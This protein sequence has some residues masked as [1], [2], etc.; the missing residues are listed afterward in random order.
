MEFISNCIV[1]ALTTIV[2]LFLCVFILSIFII[3][4]IGLGYSILSFFQW[5]ESKLR[6]NK[7]RFK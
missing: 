1:H 3:F 4:F 6:W 2:G 5:I 7:M